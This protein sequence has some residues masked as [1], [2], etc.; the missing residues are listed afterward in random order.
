MKIWRSFGSAHSAHL[1]VIGKFKN[2]DDAKI[3]EEVVEDFVNAV[4]EQ[5]YSDLQAFQHAWEERLPTLTLLGPTAS[6]FDMG[7]DQPISVERN[8]QT[9]TVSNIVTT[10]LGG[11]IR[12]LLMKY[13]KEIKITGLTG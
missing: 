11:I 3:A 7:I 5:R 6:N 8:R 2:I 10:E 1:T 13:P 12:L 4:W 9:V